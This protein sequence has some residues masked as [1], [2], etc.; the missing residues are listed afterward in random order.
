M[1]IRVDMPADIPRLHPHQDSNA[2]QYDPFSFPVQRVSDEVLLR[3]SLDHAILALHLQ[4]AA[5]EL[6]PIETCVCSVLS[7]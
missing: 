7:E 2:T 4:A 1:R 5:G 3:G 6:F